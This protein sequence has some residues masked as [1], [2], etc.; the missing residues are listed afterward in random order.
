MGLYYLTL[1]E[2]N[3]EYRKKLMFVRIMNNIGL[4][5]KNIMNS[6]NIFNNKCAINNIIGNNIRMNNN[7]CE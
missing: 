5:G 3:L 4:S 6:F 1:M 2:R 7:I